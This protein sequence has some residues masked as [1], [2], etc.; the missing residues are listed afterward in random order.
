MPDKK[1]RLIG[2]KKLEDYEPGANR[3]QVFK[4]LKKVAKVIKPSDKHD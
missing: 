1:R 2:E 3:A 4:A